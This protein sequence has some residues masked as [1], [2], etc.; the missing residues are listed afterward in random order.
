[1]TELKK[2]AIDF[3]RKT[4]CNPKDRPDEQIE[5]LHEEELELLIGFATEI[6]KEMQEKLNDSN[7]SWNDLVEEWQKE[8]EV[9]NADR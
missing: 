2:K 1:M 8:S 6:T 7:K 9:K 5:I 4:K 3:I